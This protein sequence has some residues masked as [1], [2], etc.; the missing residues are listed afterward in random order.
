MPAALAVA[1][2]QVFDTPQMTSIAVAVD[3]LMSP[4]SA[5]RSSR[6][7]L[8]SRSEMTGSRSVMRLRI[9]STGVMTSLISLM[10]GGDEIAEEAAQVERDIVESD[11]RGA[12]VVAGIAR[13]GVGV[14]ESPA[15]VEIGRKLGKSASLP[16]L[17]TRCRWMP[18]L[19]VKV[20]DKNC[21]GSGPAFKIGQASSD[22]CC[23]CWVEQ[24]DGEIA[25]NVG[26]ACGLRRARA[27]GADRQEG[28]ACRS[29]AG[30]AT[31]H[32]Q[33]DL[34][35]AGGIGRGLDCRARRAGGQIEAVGQAQA[36]RQVEAPRRYSPPMQPEVEKPSP[37][38]PRLE[39][40][41]TE[42]AVKV[43]PSCKPNWMAS[44]PV[45]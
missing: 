5:A 17:V 40:R 31:S 4:S 35:S 39:S 18:A 32:V 30:R 21:D 45:G 33:A 12:A 7:S 36:E 1:V 10:I 19:A 25:R 24:A 9:G 41:G 37:G 26:E 38:K 27:S 16:K 29:V 23:R 22:W 2:Y 13:V 3:W 44:V 34:E 11:R 15:D 6:R 42:A 28:Q 20:A 14:E 8:P 43:L